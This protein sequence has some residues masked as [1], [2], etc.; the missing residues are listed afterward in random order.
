MR[1][2][3]G[4]S[5]Y[6]LPKDCI[7]VLNVWFRASKIQYMLEQYGRYMQMPKGAY[8]YGFTIDKNQTITFMPTP[9]KAHYFN[10]EYTIRKVA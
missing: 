1:F 6:D 9:T 2:I 5:T 4:K 8:V 3:P 10:I 7:Q